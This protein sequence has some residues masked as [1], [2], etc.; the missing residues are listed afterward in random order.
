MDELRVTGDASDLADLRGDLAAEGV[1]DDHVD[2][3]TQETPGEAAEP[4]TVAVIILAAAG[5]KQTRKAFDRWLT[6]K[7]RKYVLEHMT[8]AGW[9]RVTDVEGLFRSKQ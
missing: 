2:A 6:H 9:E 3:P 4:I 5:I 7:E 8:P 1:S